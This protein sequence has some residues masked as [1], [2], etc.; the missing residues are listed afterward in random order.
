MVRSLTDYTGANS[1]LGIGRAAAYQYAENGPR[2]L[3]ICDRDSE[4]LESYRREMSE[5]HPDVEVHARAFDA[6]DEDG[7]RTVVNDAV[8][9]YG[10][11]DVFFANAV[12]VGPHRA[13][14]DF[15]KEEFL[16]VLDVNVTR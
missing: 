5:R 2:A 14:S 12:I 15:T 6:A 10:R 16:K 11:L 3:Y 9:R 13:F 8:T 7:V 4:H 1:P